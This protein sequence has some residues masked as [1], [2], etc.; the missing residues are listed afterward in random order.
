MAKNETAARVTI[1]RV[2]SWRNL[3]QAASLLDVTETQV[4]RHISGKEFSK[5]LARRMLERGVVVER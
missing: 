2:Q 1:R 5:A 3:T 4:R